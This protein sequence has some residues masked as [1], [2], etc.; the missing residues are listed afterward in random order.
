MWL[1]VVKWIFC[2]CRH[3]VSLLIQLVK[4]TVENSFLELEWSRLSGWLGIF[5]VILFCVILLKKKR[6]KK[7]CL[8]AGSFM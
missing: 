2:K 8:A 5:R 7:S 3:S 1:A 6:R 4:Q